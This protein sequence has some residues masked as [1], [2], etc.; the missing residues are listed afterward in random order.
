MDWPDDDTMDLLPLWINYLFMT[1][2]TL[3]Q[4][5]VPS[6]Y[7]SHLEIKD[8][9]RGYI[10]SSKIE[11]LLIGCLPSIYGPINVSVSVIV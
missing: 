2:S 7:I 5:Y 11:Y 3:I 9:V 1:D 6:M 8:I 10:N 4:Y